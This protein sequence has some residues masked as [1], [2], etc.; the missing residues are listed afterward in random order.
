MRKHSA[1]FLD[2]VDKVYTNVY[3][4]VPRDCWN[5]CF[6]GFISNAVTHFKIVYLKASLTK[7]SLPSRAPATALPPSPSFLVKK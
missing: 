3:L 1:L 5:F 2:S 4:T 7:G 6:M